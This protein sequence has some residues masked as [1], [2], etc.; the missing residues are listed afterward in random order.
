ML[1]NGRTERTKSSGEDG[2]SLVE[3]MVVL[4]IL[5]ILATVV[6]INVLPSQ[7]AAMRQKAVTDIAT[8]EQA[9][10]LYKLENGKYP[11]TDQGLEA[12][13]TAPSDLQNPERYREGGYIRRLP[14][15]P[16]GNDYQ[17]VYPGENGKLDIYSL[18]ADGRLGGE[19]GDA[20]IGNWK[21]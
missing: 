4:V 2:F 13:V 3:L 10:D 19:G 8:L 11:T 20:D 18:G 7:D 6:A 12:L 5:G 16:W 9:V 14:K 15:D 17:Y 21:K 1:R